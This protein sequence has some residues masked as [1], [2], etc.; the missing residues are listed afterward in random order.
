MGALVEQHR[1]PGVPSSNPLAESGIFEH[2]SLGSH[3]IERFAALAYTIAQL[4]PFEEV[5]MGQLLE[6]LLGSRSRMRR[7]ALGVARGD[8]QLSFRPGDE[9][10]EGICTDC[11]VLFG[12][13]PE[14]STM[15]GAVGCARF[16]AWTVGQ[17]WPETI[18][19]AVALAIAMPEHRFARD[20]LTREV[21]ELAAR[22]TVLPEHVLVRMR[23]IA[24]A[25]DS[26]ERAAIP[27]G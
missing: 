10:R 18:V 8:A 22:Y 15:A 4:S 3:S 24:G 16:V 17:P 21:L 14:M 13:S 5:D 6:S 1:V 23:M 7:V 27:S 11:R 20:V 19:Q 26:T 9:H 2:D 12:Q 25:H